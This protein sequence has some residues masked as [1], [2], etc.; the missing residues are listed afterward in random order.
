MI[1]R[2]SAVRLLSLTL[3]LALLG[4]ACA[5]AATPAPTAPPTAT[6]EPPQKAALDKLLQDAAAAGTFNGAALVAQNGQI[7]LSQGYGLAD[8]AQKIANTP[9]TKIRIGEITQV[10]TAMAILMLQERGKLSLQDKLCTYL[11][12]CPEAWK[13]VTL[14]QLLAHTSGIP[15][16]QLFNQT[17]DQVLASLEKWPLK[18]KPG[19]QQDYSHTGY[20]A[21]GK[22]IEAASGQ[23]YEAFVQQNIFDPLKMTRT[24]YDHGQA[25][26]A[27]GYTDPSAQPATLPDPQGM[28][29]SG[30][31]YSTVEDLNRWDQALYTEQL[32]SAK[33][34]AAMFTPSPL[35]SLSTGWSN[36]YA[37]WIHA[38]APHVVESA[39]GQVG[40]SALYDRYPDQK[41]IVILLANQQTD[42][43]YDLS[44]ALTQVMLGE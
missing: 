20:I 35:P 26:L 37:F 14:E 40:I 16:T 11:K 27:I 12:G 44:G 2:T 10:F 5:P 13:D 3:L 17:P 38:S 4:A 15:D 18:F 34:L 28:Y 29:A 42:T 21:L 24:G 41:V 25:D 8:R 1:H 19:S 23:T 31:L 9:Q 36:G 43:L 6:P 30:A 22:V 39:G 33:S 7:I 32:V